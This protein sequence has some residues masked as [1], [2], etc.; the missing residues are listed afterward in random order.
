MWLCMMFCDVICGGSW[1]VISITSIGVEAHSPSKPTTM[2]SSPPRSP[3]N[4]SRHRRS[5]SLQS[6]RQSLVRSPS[7][8]TLTYHHNIIPNIPT[9]ALVES[10]AGA[11]HYSGVKVES[12]GTVHKRRR[13]SHDFGGAHTQL[14]HG[15]QRIL[16][17]LRELYEL[18][19]TLEIFERSWNKDAEFEDPWSKCKGYQEYAA[20]WF[21]LPKVY[22]K[23]T[24]NVARV[25]S[26][27]LT[28]NRLIFSQ[29]QT[30]TT[31]YI[32]RKKTVHSII[33]VDLDDDDKIIKLI[34]QW[35]GKDLPSRF[36]AYYLRVLN[37]KITP[38]IFHIP[39]ARR[40]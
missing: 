30:Y 33:V 1:V 29:A 38:W 6:S 20:Q 4:Q 27:T 14:K 26:S 19:P 23:S 34:D 31:K 40:V 8:P 12:E 32:K 2:P 25:M 3:T 18:R 7:P 16:D 24:T 39:K 28:P 13:S 10:V 21:A 17:D 36:G 11:A 9:P 22:S 35:D 15:H 37:A 5:S